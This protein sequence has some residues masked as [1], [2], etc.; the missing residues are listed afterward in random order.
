MV[1]EIGEVCRGTVL[2]MYTTELGGRSEV[3]SLLN[4]PKFV[5]ELESQPHRCCCLVPS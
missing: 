3:E 5:A 1:E 2:V 4:L